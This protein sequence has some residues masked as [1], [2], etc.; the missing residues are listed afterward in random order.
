ML[1]VKRV[2]SCIIKVWQC[3]MQEVG[4]E[5]CK[6]FC[7]KCLTC[8]EAWKEIFQFPSKSERPVSKGI[9]AFT[10]Q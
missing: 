4:I 2:A 6:K 10:F 8:L 9:D 7:Q 3:I 1:V 5:G